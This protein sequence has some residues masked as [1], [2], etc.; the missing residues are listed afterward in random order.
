MP[1]NPVCVDNQNAKPAKMCISYFFLAMIMFYPYYIWYAFVYL[2]YIYISS[3][4]NIYLIPSC[5][6]MEIQLHIAEMFIKH[7]KSYAN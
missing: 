5:S 2:I 7:G 6:V 1:G 3:E 4:I